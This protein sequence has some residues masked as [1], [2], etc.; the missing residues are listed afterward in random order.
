MSFLLLRES[1]V[2]TEANEKKIEQKNEETLVMKEDL[3]EK[4]N[5]LQKSNIMAEFKY[6]APEKYENGNAEDRF[7]RSCSI[8]SRENSLEEEDLFIRANDNARIREANKVSRDKNNISMASKID[9]SA[10]NNSISDASTREIRSMFEEDLKKNSLVNI[11]KLRYDL[12]IGERNQRD[13]LSPLSFD[14]ANLRYTENC[15]A[16]DL[17]TNYSIKSTGILMQIKH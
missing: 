12:S 4:A 2:T 14:Y 13:F 9:L 8:Y 15:P 6:Q 10:I 16:E 7:D 1:S 17:K 11:N 3:I 5:E